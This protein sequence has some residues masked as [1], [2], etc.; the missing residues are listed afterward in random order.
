MVRL[1]QG[2]WEVTRELPH[3][4]KMGSWP[5]GQEGWT[6]ARP[7]PLGRRGTKPRARGCWEG[8]RAAPQ[9]PIPHTDP[10]GNAPTMA[11]PSHFSW[12]IRGTCPR[13]AWAVFEGCGVWLTWLMCGRCP[14]RD[15][16]RDKG[17]SMAEDGS[18]AARAL[19]RGG[20]SG[21]EACVLGGPHDVGQVQRG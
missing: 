20:V 13:R 2:Q 15:K 4:R 18:H 9:W 8:R 16:G 6:G 12:E 5:C 7:G 17:L 14:G 3:G 21:R 19:C 10:L 11:C 1:L